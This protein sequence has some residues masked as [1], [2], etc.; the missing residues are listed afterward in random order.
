MY[1]LKVVSSK[2]IYGTMNGGTVSLKNLNASDR[3][4]IMHRHNIDVK[5]EDELKPFKGEIFREHRKLFG[6]DN[7]FDW[8]KMFMANQVTKDGSH[9][10]ITEESVKNNPN[11]WTDINEDILVY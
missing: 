4:L 5:S 3:E 7:G 11:G 10:E 2:N 1:K 8:H 6:D 9:F